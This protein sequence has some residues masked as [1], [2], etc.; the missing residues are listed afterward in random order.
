MK[1]KINQSY[2]VHGDVINTLANQMWYDLTGKGKI[3]TAQFL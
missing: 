3:N 2:T 1:Y